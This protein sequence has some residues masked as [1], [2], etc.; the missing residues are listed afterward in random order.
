MPG[1]ARRPATSAQPTF[2]AGTPSLLRTINERSVLELIRSSGPVSRAQVARDSG[3]SKP[4]VSV[5]LA[6]LVAGGLVLETGRTRGRRG[7]GAVLYEVNPTAGW[8]AAVDV[9]RHWLRAA[10]ADLTGAVVARRDERARIRSAATLIGQIGDVAH[11]LAAEAGIRWSQVTH[12]TIGSPGVFDHARGLVE[13]AANLPGWGRHGLVEAVRERLGPEVGFENDV[14]LA[15][16]GEQARGLGR[17]VADFA[18]LWVGT[19][20]GMGLV[21]GGELYRGAHGAAGEI[22]Y[23][24]LGDRDPH[25]R[26]VRRRGAFEE[27]A[28]ADGIV[29]TARSFGMKPPLT[30]QKVF[31][32]ARRGERAARRAVEE[33]A[34]RLALAVATV[35]PLLDPDLVVL[36][37]GVGAN[38][39]L[40]LA[41]LDQELRRLTSFRPRLAVSALGEDA[42]LH[43]AIA[44]ALEAARDRLFH[45]ASTGRAR[46]AV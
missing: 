24:P 30:P 29:R 42:V 16:L 33:E 35:G 21:L 32:A 5:A 7:P 1:A 40:L 23:L 10:I 28:G 37:G 27:A 38:G 25:E 11:G 43:G 22:A 8:V 45:R 41:P 17:G 20:V 44:T 3:L 19:G 26:S 13:H 15:A 18:F 46:T 39:D 6:G 36:G 9:G 2:P 34:R 14:N 12:A 31:A 4:T